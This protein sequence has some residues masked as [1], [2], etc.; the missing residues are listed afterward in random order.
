MTIGPALSRARVCVAPASAARGCGPVLAGV[1][2][3]DLSCVGAADAG[4]CVDLVAQGLAELAVLQGEPA[5]QNAD[6]WR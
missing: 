5:P 6:C 1:T 4:G 2:G 3:A